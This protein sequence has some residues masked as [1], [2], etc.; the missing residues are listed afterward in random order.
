MDSYLELPVSSD[1]SFSDGKVK[2]EDGGAANALPTE[3]KVR[4]ARPQLHI[5]RCYYNVTAADFR[6]F[7]I[8]WV[9]SLL[10]TVRIETLIQ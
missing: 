3:S 6:P 2:I 4:H 7:Q 9:S 1:V 8:Y 10:C 5:V